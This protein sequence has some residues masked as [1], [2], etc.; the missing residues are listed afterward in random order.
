MAPPPGYVCRKCNCPG[1]FID[2]C[3]AGALLKQIEE[4]RRMGQEVPAFLLEIEEKL[5]ATRRVN[6]AAFSSKPPPPG[7]VC[8]KC[9]VPGHW[10]ESCTAPSTFRQ[11][12]Q[13]GGGGMG[14]GGGGMQQLQQQQQGR[15]HGGYVCKICGAPGDHYIHN[16]PQKAASRMGRR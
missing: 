12:Q 11:Q 2:D 5:Q 7:Y 1:H 3:D 4:L 13:G 8:K 14:G 10:V 9:N 15:P 6:A 16:C